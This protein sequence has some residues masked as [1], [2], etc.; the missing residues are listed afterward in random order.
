[1]ANV[2]RDWWM[3]RREITFYLSMIRQ[4]LWERKIEGKEKFFSWY[5]KLS[6]IDSHAHTHTEDLRSISITLVHICVWQNEGKRATNLPSA[7]PF[8]RQQLSRTF[9]KFISKRQSE[10]KRVGDFKQ[11]ATAEKKNQHKA[12]NERINLTQKKKHIHFYSTE[13]TEA[14]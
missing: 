5:S 3:K 2:L 10:R 4:L 6:M 8:R 11:R 7:V 1:M 14:V 13:E 12:Q 9:T